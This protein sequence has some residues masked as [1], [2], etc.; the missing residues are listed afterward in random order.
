MLLKGHDCLQVPLDSTNEE[1]VHPIHWLIVYP[2]QVLHE[3][4]H[5]EQIYVF[6]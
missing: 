2:K 5:C 4:W 1:S 3:G 6:A